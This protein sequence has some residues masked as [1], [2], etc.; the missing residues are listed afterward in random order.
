MVVYENPDRLEASQ[1]FV[2]QVPCSAITSQ[3]FCETFLRIHKQG[4]QRRI[5]QE[6]EQF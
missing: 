3:D 4:P 1:L 2:N 6:I 5:I